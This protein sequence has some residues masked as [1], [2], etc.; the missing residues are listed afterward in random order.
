MINPK[1][2]IQKIGDSYAP[3]FGHY[4]GAMMPFYDYKYLV[5]FYNSCQ[6]LA[7]IVE[8]ETPEYM[9]LKEAERVID[10]HKNQKFEFIEV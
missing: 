8:I 9:T 2:R 6:L 4:V 7:A 10:F 5:R 3:Q 1:Y